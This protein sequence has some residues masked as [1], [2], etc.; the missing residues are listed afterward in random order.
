MQMTKKHYEVYELDTNGDG[1][2][3]WQAIW[4]KNEL[5]SIYRGTKSDEEICVTRMQT[6]NVAKGKKR[7][8]VN[9]F[10]QL[11]DEFISETASFEKKYK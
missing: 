7:F 1:S 5:I 4:D 2:D 3:V 6:I 10:L 11:V 9:E 8:T